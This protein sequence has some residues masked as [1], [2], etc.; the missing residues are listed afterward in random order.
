M[1]TY[2]ERITKLSTGIELFLMIV[3]ICLAATVASAQRQMENLGRGVVA[4]NK[5]SGN[6]YVGWRMLGIDPGN[7][8]FNV[9]RSTGGGAAIKLNAS[10]ITATT[11]EL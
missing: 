8:G 2:Q 6:V 3:A 10:P 7:I 5:G 1:K 11:E 9:Y 4:I